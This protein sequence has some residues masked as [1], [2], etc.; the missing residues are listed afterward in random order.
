MKQEK[1]LVKQRREQLLI[2]VLH[3]VKADLDDEEI[4]HM[5]L[6]RTLSSQNNADTPDTLGQRAADRIARFA[7]SWRFI[8]LFTMV[9]VVWMAGNT[10]VLAHRSF[11]PYP[12]I[13]LNLVL[14]CLAA[15][16]APMI[17]MAQNRQEEKDRRRSINGYR[18]GLKTE[19]IMSDI[20]SKLDALLEKIN[21]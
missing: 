9:L 13:L 14:S 5:L 7:G 15:V 8:G 17:M 11:D 4:I 2:H 10:W 1:S 18:V 19:V 12:Y 6:D 3:D 20:H 21:E 16:Q